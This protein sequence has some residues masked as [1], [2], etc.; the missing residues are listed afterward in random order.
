MNP[1]HYFPKNAISV[2]LKNTK[3]SVKD[4]NGTEMSTPSVASGKD[5]HGAIPVII[6]QNPYLRVATWNIRSLYQSEK[7]E[8]TVYRMKLLK[9]I[10]WA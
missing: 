9:L 1:L 4:A 8:N 10:S 2:V 7:L 5:R 6:Q 3:Q